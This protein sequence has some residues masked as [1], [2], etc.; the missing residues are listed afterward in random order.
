MLALGQD[1][2]VADRPDRVLEQDR[3]AA[4]LALGQ[5]RPAVSLALG[6]HRPTADL[7]LGQYSPVNLSAGG[8]ADCVMRLTVY[9]A[10]VRFQQLVVPYLSWLRVVRTVGVVR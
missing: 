5:N 1:G 2:P 8:C 6:Q 9:G 3:A 10:V 7:A 4:D